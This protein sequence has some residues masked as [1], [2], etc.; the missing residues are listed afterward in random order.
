MHWDIKP[1][2]ILINKDNIIKVCD[3]GW[4]CEFDVNK[5]RTSVCGTFE[6][7]APEIF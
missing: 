3:F 7:M 1:E 6:Y 2:N 4:S 5:K